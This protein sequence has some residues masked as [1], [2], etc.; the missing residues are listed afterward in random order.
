M[1]ASCPFLVLD[2]AEVE[3]S[4]DTAGVALGFIADSGLLVGV[5]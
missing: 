5:Q 2:N 4:K 3:G 1:G